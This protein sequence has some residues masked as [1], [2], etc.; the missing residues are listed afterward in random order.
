M[1]RIR[2][3]LREMGHLMRTSPLTTPLRLVYWSLSGNL[4]Q[5]LKYHRARRIILAS[6]LFD[7][8]YYLRRNPSVTIEPLHHYLIAGAAE[9][10]NPCSLFE[11]DYYISQR[12]SLAPFAGNPLL[13][14]IQTGAAQGRD[15]HPLF[16]VSS[17]L[18][19][20]PDVA[21]KGIEPLKHYL[22]TGS[23]EGRT[24]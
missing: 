24:L 5:K 7:E 23:R 1:K 8:V 15:P 3:G 18:H 22:T 17:Y 20:Y 2:I 9:G 6:G 13:H 14:Y 10:Y 16:S 4:N 21:N 11:S 19:R 12:P